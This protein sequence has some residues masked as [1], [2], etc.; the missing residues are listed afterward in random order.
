VWSC[1]LTQSI[2]AYVRKGNEK[3]LASEGLSEN[4]SLRYA[5]T[6]PV[7]APTGYLR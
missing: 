2:Q 1:N 3:K 4:G 6:L 5:Q 7:H